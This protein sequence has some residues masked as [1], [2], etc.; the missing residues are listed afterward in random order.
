[1]GVNIFMVL[2][3]YSKRDTQNLSEFLMQVKVASKIN[4]FLILSKYE[5]T[6]KSISFLSLSDKDSELS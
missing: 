3:F 2:N 5:S 4:L 1:M 6:Y